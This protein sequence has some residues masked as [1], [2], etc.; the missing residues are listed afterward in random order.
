MGLML[1]R[2]KA[3]PKDSL[4]DNLSGD[5]LTLVALKSLIALSISELREASS[6]AGI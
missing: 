3:V 1:K 6:C 5:Y 2:R 4:S